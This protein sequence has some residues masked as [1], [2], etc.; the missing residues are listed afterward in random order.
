[1]SREARARYLRLRE[2][3][4]DTFG[5]IDEPCSRCGSYSHWSE[6]CPITDIQMDAIWDAKTESGR[7]LIE[8]E[9]YKYAQAATQ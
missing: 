4:L 6:S 2:E 3:A 9:G 1:M 7:L 8:R 5:E